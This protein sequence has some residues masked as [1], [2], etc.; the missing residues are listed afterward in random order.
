MLLL[1]GACQSGEDG[2]TSTAT[3]NVVSDEAHQGDAG[4]F[5][6]PP[7]VSAPSLVGAFDPSLSPVVRI[8]ELDATT[9][10][11]TARGLIATYT[12][13][14]GPGSE[15]VRV[16]TSDY[17]VNW[18]T[19]DFA[20]DVARLYRIEVRLGTK[21]AGYADVRPVA[22]GNLLK[23]VDTSQD[24]PLLDDTTLPIKFF[25]NGCAPVVCTAA[26]A[27]HTA[28]VCDP[29]TASCSSPT[30][31]DGT[32][33]GGGT[34]LAGVCTP[35]RCTSMTL[36]VAATYSV[37][38][39]SLPVELK[40][41][42]LN[43]DGWLDVAVGGYWTGV[44]TFLGQPDGS[45]VTKGMYSKGSGGA[46]SLDLVDLDGDGILDALLGQYGGYAVA[47]LRGVGDGGFEP[48]ITIA[49][50]DNTQ[51]ASAWDVNGDGRPD[52]LAANVD[53][54][55]S[56]L[57]QNADHTFGAPTLYTISTAAFEEPYRIVAHDLDGD[58]FVDLAVSNGISLAVLLGNGTGQF[59]AVSKYPTLGGDS[60]GLAL[61]D[62]DGDGHVDAALANRATG[63][64]DVL[65]GHADGSF[66]AAT[67]YQADVGAYAITVG[68]VDN[69]G[70]PDLVTA[71]QQSGDVSLLLNQGD[72]T[73]HVVSPLAPADQGAGTTGV[74][75]ADVDRDGKL[76][77]LVCELGLDEMRMLRNT[78]Q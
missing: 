55:I 53:G 59:G 30:A 18:H 8:T 76:D 67:S 68:D 29:S 46:S 44:T 57:L 25:L 71:N 9:L 10:L 2:D 24:I 14:S 20:L 31:A 77:V 61:A 36:A 50:G 58:G 74:A 21:V 75:L 5:F 40:T 33:C 78:C 48:P 35:D 41:D 4:L 16:E 43:G 73:F 39:G 15:R 23:N 62:L 65:R 63:I 47:I 54:T 19:K 13:T 11:P 56:V 52:I 72:G 64:V 37:P 3:A 70:W 38:P 28:G 45:F 7:M 27:C 69:D 1:A 49:T 60:I 32:A 17:I 51:L 34:C 6:L 12:T 22:T 66:G 26:D 42:D